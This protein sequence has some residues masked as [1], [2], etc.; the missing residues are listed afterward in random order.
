MKLTTMKL[1]VATAAA[2]LVLN[3][4]GPG[5]TTSSAPPANPAPTASSPKVDKAVAV[6]RDLESSD[7]VDQ[8]L[9]KH[10]LTEQQFEDLMYEIASDPALSEQYSAKLG[11]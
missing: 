11:R 6:A 8:V 2:L 9:Q 3:A 10:G 4:C 7:Q 1:V 5:S